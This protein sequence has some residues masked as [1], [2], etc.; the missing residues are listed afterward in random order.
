MYHLVSR[1]V[2]KLP[3][4]TDA[5]SRRR[6]LDL[7]D[8]VTS[9]YCWELHAYCLMTNHYHLLVTTVEPTLSAGMQYLLSHYAQWFD[10]RYDYEGHV[11]ERRFYSAE[12]TTD[13]HLLA[14]ARYILLNPVRADLCTRAAD[15]RWS[16][17]RATAGLTNEGPR[18][19]D[20]LLLYQ[21]GRRLGRAR[22]RF[23]DFIN[24]EEALVRA[25]P[26][27]PG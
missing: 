13:Q 3:I 7:L 10:W 25:T 2:R 23:A 19:C 20:D 12:V 5:L 8:G 6:F 1:G 11:L 4:Y 9:E 21:F 14:S 22:E 18:L 15:W 27:P 24:S 17:Y 26:T 16:S